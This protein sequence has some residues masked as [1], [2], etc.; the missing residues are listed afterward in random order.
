[1]EKVWIIFE[2][3][4]ELKQKRPSSIYKNKVF[5]EKSTEFLNQQV[6][7][8]LMPEFLIYYIKEFSI[9]ETIDE[10]EEL[11]KNINV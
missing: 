8:K 4:K 11:N 1:M 5:A 6:K 9:F 10:Y 7:N 2:E 3:H